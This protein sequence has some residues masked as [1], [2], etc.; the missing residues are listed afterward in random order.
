MSFT[1]WMQ[2]A[3][4]T[5]A[6]Y[7]PTTSKISLT[8]QF[9]PSWR[10]TLPV[11]HFIGSA[12]H[13]KNTFRSTVLSMALRLHKWDKWA[14]L[15]CLS[16]D[17]VPPL[18]LCHTTSCHIGFVTATAASEKLLAQASNHFKSACFSFSAEVSTYQGPLAGIAIHNN[19]PPIRAGINGP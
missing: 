4:R 9:R 5:Q 8:R 6:D 10:N 7:P 1:M 15:Q 12:S 2:I 14:A 11:S 16:L 18:F 13:G 17:R 19:C 3:C